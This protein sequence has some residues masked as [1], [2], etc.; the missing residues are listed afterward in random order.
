MDHLDRYRAKRDP[1]KTPEPGVATDDDPAADE[2]I[3]STESHKLSFVIQK[4][5]ARRLHYDFR[6][7]SEGVMPSWAVPKGPS[8]DP[9]TNR[10]AMHV[11]D[12]PLDYQRFEGV[13]PKGE[14]G[15]GSVIVWDRG[16]YEN[17]SELDG[18]PIDLRAAIEKGHVTVWMHG[19]KLQGG[20][21][22]IRTKDDAWILK[23]RN[24]D[25]ADPA[26]DITQ[27]RPESVV[28]GL[29]VEQIGSSEK[30]K[31]WTRG[32]ATY[33]PAMLAE[34]AKTAPVGDEWIFEQKL[35]GL[36]CV[37]VRNGDEIDLWSRNHLSFNSRFP[38]VVSALKRLP[39]DN[40]VLDG[41]LVAMEDGKSS[42]LSLQQGKG[43]GRYYCI[44]DMLHLL[45]NDMR[46]LPWSERKALLN[47]FFEASQTNPEGPLQLVNPLVGSFDELWDRACEQK[48]EGLIAK[49]VD[50]QYVSGRS[51][52]WRKLKTSMGQEF[53]VGGWTAPKNS[54]AGLGAL[55]VGYYDGDQFRYAGKVGSGLNHENLRE[56]TKELI[57]SEV[58]QCP[59]DETVRERT[60]RWA[61]PSIVVDVVFGEWTTAGKLRHPRFAGR[62]SDKSPREV[63]RE[64]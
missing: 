40:F 7:E 49:R 24:D 39:V 23:K 13:I 32:H 41:E 61:R 19:E 55:L 14:Y 35:D 28:S 26:L 43:Q 17:L 45:G 38:E 52:N 18:K 22:L 9:K 1:S 63:S 3:T 21:S 46:E 58:E 15:G 47:R 8:H 29:T 10:L 36:R 6:L 37:A 34:P 25:H 48:W 11:E 16:T 51:S 20:W 31:E 59:F 30:P 50:A 53:V 33:A 62:R 44:F 54:R 56:L 42:F 57:D 64:T 2:T 12:H 27:T 4:H 5:A 60:A